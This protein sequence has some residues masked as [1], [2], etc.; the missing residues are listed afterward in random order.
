MKPFLK[1][2][3]AM[4]IPYAL[5]KNNL[6]PEPDDYA[7]VVQT[8]RSVGFEEIADRMIDQGSTVNKPD[9]LAVLDDMEKACESILLE[10][11]RVILGGLV[12]MFPRV[13]GV[14]TSKSDEFDPSRHQ[15][16]VGANPGRRVRKTLREK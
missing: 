4:P 7:A 1:R 15:I 11:N 3:L 6:T 9:I 2:R 5:F 8:Y 14:F 10:G 16:D 13:R 12:Q